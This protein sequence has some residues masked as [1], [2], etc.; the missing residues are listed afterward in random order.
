MSWCRSLFGEKS[1][2]HN[3]GVS[4]NSEEEENRRLDI[5]QVSAAA[6]PLPQRCAEFSIAAAVAAMSAQHWHCIHE[7]GGRLKPKDS[8][9]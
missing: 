6:V 1:G 2:Y 4:W 8:S 3:E 7:C 9:P 5:N